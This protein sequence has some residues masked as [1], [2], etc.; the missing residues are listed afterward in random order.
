[1]F[2][3]DIHSDISLDEAQG[4]ILIHGFFSN[5]KK[6]SINSL[7]L[8]LV[9]NGWNVWTIDYES[10]TNLNNMKNDVGTEL[11]MLPFLPMIGHSMGGILLSSLIN[12][13]VRS[14]Y[15]S[16]SINS[17]YANCSIDVQANVD[18]LA[19]GKK[20]VYYTGTHGLDND[21]I[22]KLVLDW[23]NSVW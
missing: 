1:M 21:V 23:L 7:R 11:I 17:P 22:R 9:S 2:A 16:M 4:V 12:D 8:F 6:M 14:Q 15:P 13:G 18:P 19:A 10:S 3:H 5:S 20:D